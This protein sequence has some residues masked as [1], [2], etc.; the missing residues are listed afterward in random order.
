MQ[1]KCG[2][3][4]ALFVFNSFDNNSSWYEWHGPLDEATC[5][6]CPEARRRS[7]RRRGKAIRTSTLKLCYAH[8]GYAQLEIK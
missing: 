2:R 4:P 3:V 1:G 8:L 5:E 6:E 7:K